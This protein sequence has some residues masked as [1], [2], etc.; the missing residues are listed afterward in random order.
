MEYVFSSYCKGDSEIGDQPFGIQVRNVR[1][2]K[3]HKWGHI[4]IDKECPMFKEGISINSGLDPLNKPAN[5]QS[6]PLILVRKLCIYVFSDMIF[7]KD[8]FYLY[9]YNFLYLFIFIKSLILF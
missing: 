8:I 4:N 1:C 6:D 5:D 3:C 9:Y 2:I 7:Y